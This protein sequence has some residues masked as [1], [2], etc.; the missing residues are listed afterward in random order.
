L[1]KNFIEQELKIFAKE[2]S[3]LLMQNSDEDINILKATLD[4]F[5]KSVIVVKSK[6]EAQK[7][8]IANSFDMVII[9][10]NFENSFG[11]LK[12]CKMVRDR[13]EDQVIV[14][15]G[16]IN[17]NLDTDM[18]IDLL[19]LKVATFIPHLLSI[20][21]ALMKIMELSEK[22][23]YSKI[24]LI[25][26]QEQKQKQKEEKKEK[27]KSKKSNVDESKKYIQ[28]IEKTQKEIV[29]AVH[30]NK[31]SAIEFIEDLAKKDDFRL[32]KYTIDN[33][34]DLYY[35]FEKLIYDFVYPE[36][37]ISIKMKDQLVGILFE[38]ED[39]LFKLD[40]FDKLAEMFGSLGYYIEGIDIDNF[41]SK[42]YQIMWYLNDDLK[43]LIHH[44]FTKKDVDNIHFLDESIVSSLQQL[45][46]NF[47]KTHV[48]SSDEEEIELF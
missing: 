6:K 10:V 28:N 12:A 14:L 37:K 46:D 17:S 36:D 24:D 48:D 39:L 9:S 30:H 5:F 32:L 2:Q 20:E 44:I 7:A 33:L 34:N 40:E 13:K 29:E 26:K 47:D 4:N 22:I 42:T 18:F 41:N 23:V 11:G 45:K 8:L 15:N 1:D 27:I 19:E 3:I 38:Y 35:E 31:K 25:N 16:D 21:F 43:K